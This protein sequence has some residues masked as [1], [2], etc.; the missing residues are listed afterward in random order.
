MLHTDGIKSGLAKKDPHNF[1]ARK[2]FL[3]YQTEVFKS[4]PDAEFYIKNNISLKFQIPF[5]SIEV[6]GS[7]KTGF[8]FFK[9]KKFEKGQS[10]LDIAI[11]SLPLFNKFVE[12]TH[13]LT[14]GYSDLTKFPIFKGQNTV[15]QFRRGLANGFVNPFFMVDS[16]FKSNW[17][18]FF[19][20]LSNSYFD[21]FKN[22]N[23]GVYA[24]E[25]FFEYKQEE[26]IRKYITNPEKYDKI[27]SPV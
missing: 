4:D 18:D 7:S 5:S 27:S 3:S 2:I 24:S 13:S 16:I 12:T 14:K 19:N 25:Y 11:I 22:I 15:D 10:D 23:G 20:T 1:I 9:D 26:C 21:M 8:S 17:I 6:A